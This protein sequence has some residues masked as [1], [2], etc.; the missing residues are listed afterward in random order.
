MR[1]LCQLTL[2][3]RGYLYYLSLGNFNQIKIKLLG[4]TYFF[5][6]F[7]LVILN[8]KFMYSN[9][10]RL[11]SKSMSLILCLI[12]MILILVSSLKLVL[13]KTSLLISL[14]IT[15]STMKFLGVEM[16]KGRVAWVLSL[17]MALMFNLL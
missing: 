3:E 6:F 2:G 13:M 1:L 7:A 10:D 11:G 4:V 9:L 12:S 17:G 15:V 8:M 5:F 14:L 16:V